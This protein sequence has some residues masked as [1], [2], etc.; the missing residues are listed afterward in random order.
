MKSSPFVL[1]CALALLGPTLS[2]AEPSLEAPRL[3]T[4]E[5]L[6]KLV[7]P[8]ALYPDPLVAIL[9]PAATKPA[10][11]VLAAR[12]LDRGGNAELAD[13][14]DW[15]ESVK[16]LT[17]YREVVEFLD[18]N[19]DWTRQL[20]EAFF[21]Q[22]D[23]VMAAI[24]SVR[25]RARADGLLVDT[26]QQAVLL[27][28][29]IIRVVPATPTI[30]YVPRYDPE[31]FWV[32]RDY[33]R[34]NWLSF[35]IGYS[36][37]AWL[38]YD[39]DWRYRS[40]YVVSRPV[41]WYHA[42]DWRTCPPVRPHPAKRWQPSGHHARRDYDGPRPDRRDRDRPGTALSP[43][44]ER[45]WNRSMPDR[46][47]PDAQRRSADPRSS[48]RRHR[49][50]PDAVPPSSA[51]VST[52][53]PE[54]VGQMPLAA[55]VN[56]PALPQTT[57]TTAVT[58]PTV[59][60]P[61]A[62]PGRR[63]REDLPRRDYRPERDSNANRTVR[64]PDANRPARVPDTNRPARN[65]ETPRVAPAPQPSRTSEPAS[66]PRYSAPAPRN[67]PPARTATPEPRN[68][69]TP[70]RAERQPENREKEAR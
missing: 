45:D 7:G 34:F 23:D 61:D 68:N 33:D 5:E 8:I 17:H 62:Q 14:E 54:V 11:I 36:V 20:G 24:Q 39:L 37:G 15:D 51:T 50:R 25:A 56:L 69:S 21:D 58:T 38:A 4:T 13:R 60:T 42:P 41:H 3:R 46:N 27:E 32:R 28:D 18:R 55:P 29:G 16:A 64:V 6:E 26:A 57:T 49:D 22:P 31:V 43:E 52:S 53:A 10:E 70:N 48:E 65:S 63:N 40:L 59:T 66:A 12:F 47:R 9:L 44:R 35:G 19:L 67:D 2:L 1:A 30:I